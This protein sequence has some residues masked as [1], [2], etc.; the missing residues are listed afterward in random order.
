LILKDAPEGAKVL[1]LAALHQA[2][3]EA[4]KDEPLVLVKLSQGF[5]A[6]AP[7]ITLDAALLMRDGDIRGGIA[8]LLADPADADAL[9]KDGLT[10]PD[11]AELTKFLNA[12]LGESLAS[13]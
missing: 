10:A 8:G 5:V 13:S 3:A 4:R 6:L 12:S 1:D 9:L 2:R 7:E 11:I